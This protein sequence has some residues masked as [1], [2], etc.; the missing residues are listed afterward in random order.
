[1]LRNKLAFENAGSKLS[2][3]K[4]QQNNLGLR[5]YMEN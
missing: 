5:I 4:I 1:M 2:K 3:Y